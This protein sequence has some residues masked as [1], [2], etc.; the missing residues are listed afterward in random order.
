MWVDCKASLSRRKNVIIQCFECASTLASSPPCVDLT[1]HMTKLMWRPQEN[2]DNVIF[3]ELRGAL[4]CSLPQQ[5]DI[6][7]SESCSL[8]RDEMWWI[9]SCHFFCVFFSTFRHWRD[10]KEAACKKQR[11]VVR[12]IASEIRKFYMCQCAILNT[13]LETVERVHSP[14]RISM[15]VEFRWFWLIELIC[16]LA[17]LFSFFFSFEIP[18]LN[19]L[20]GAYINM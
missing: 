14:L 9:I 18:S 16:K 7:V 15:S 1:V 13:Q 8:A 17:I 12:W 2:T 3:L 11:Q 6:H 4:F 10:Q 5:N 20:G 19:S